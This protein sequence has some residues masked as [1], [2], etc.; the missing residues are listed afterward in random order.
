MYRPIQNNQSRLFSF[1]PRNVTFEHSQLLAQGGILQGDLFSDRGESEDETNRK[2]QRRSTWRGESPGIASKNQL[3]GTQTRF[4]RTTTITK[5]TVVTNSSVM[6]I[7]TTPTSLQQMAFDLLQVSC[8]NLYLVT[9]LLKSTHPF[10]S[11]P[12][13]RC[14]DR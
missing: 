2:P 11:T 1:W 4:W 7:V 5:N 14:R 8:V 9:Y 6:Q 13:P 12:L 3:F 10:D